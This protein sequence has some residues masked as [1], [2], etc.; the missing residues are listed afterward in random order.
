MTST[1]ISLNVRVILMMKNVGHCPENRF[2]TKLVDFYVRSSINVRTAVMSGYVSCA[3]VFATLWTEFIAARRTRSKCLR[4]LRSRRI[5]LIRVLRLV[6]ARSWCFC[7][8]FCMFTCRL[9]R[10]V[11]TSLRVL[12]ALHR[13]T[14]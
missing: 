1:S 9:W 10:L 3:G 4:W 6:L 7:A 5:V 11:W 14:I 2:L 13:R 12:V 8:Q